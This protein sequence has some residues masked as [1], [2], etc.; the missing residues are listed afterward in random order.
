MREREFNPD[1]A[2]ERAVGVF[3]DKG[4]FDTSMDDLINAMGVAR[5][6]VYNTWGSKRELFIAALEKFAEIN[7]KKYHAVLHKDGASLP[8]ILEFFELMKNM[9][10]EA[11][12]GCMVCN[13]ATEVAPHDEEI[14]KACRRVL[15]RL[16][17]SLKNALR[18]AVEKK[19]LRT[20][21]DL[22][23]LAKYLTGI[24]RNASVMT[25]AGYSGDEIGKQIDIAVSVLG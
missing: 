16:S 5:Y 21:H 17:K 1:Q 10:E 18:N 2:L 7:E 11:R 15:D 23:D 6:G 22:D 9:P 24:L 14:A 3:W 25:R 12:C 8:E 19:E 13:T 4:Y 20:S